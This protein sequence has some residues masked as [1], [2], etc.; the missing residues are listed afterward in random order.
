MKSYYLILLAAITLLSGCAKKQ[1][2]IS[3]VFAAANVTYMNT[4]LDGSITVRARGEG[5]NRRD[6]REQSA[7]N[8]VYE[9]IFN[10]V[11][12][13]G[14]AQL[15]EPLL[16]TLHAKERYEEFFNTFFADGGDYKQF[17]SMKDRKPDTDKEVKGKR[18]TQVTQTL[19]IARAQ[20][21]TYLIEQGIIQ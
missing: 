17:V 6:A 13:P 5:R 8:A 15:S 21:R 1:Y 2:P 9:V 16:S 20:L 3:S 14:N 12:V 11:D 7:K 10:G 18:Q 4:E 19:R